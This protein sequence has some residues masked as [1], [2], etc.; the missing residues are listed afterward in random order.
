MQD[1]EGGFSLK[2]IEEETIRRDK[3]ADIA[4]TARV[5][6]W[7]ETVDDLVGALAFYNVGTR[8]RDELIACV[9]IATGAA[10]LRCV[11]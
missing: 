2:N 6:K 3:L 7:S 5:G 11:N 10:H 9:R 8:Q 4:V 1:I